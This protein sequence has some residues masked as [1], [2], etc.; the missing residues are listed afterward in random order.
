MLVNA[1]DVLSSTQHLAHQLLALCLWN[2]C[3]MTSLPPRFLDVVIRGPMG[4]GLTREL[5][6][7]HGL[8]ELTH[9]RLNNKHV[10]CKVDGA[11]SMVDGRA[12]SMVD[13]R[14]PPIISFGVT[15]IQGQIYCWRIGCGEHIC[16]ALAGDEHS[17]HPR[18]HGWVRVE[19][20][21]PRMPG[22]LIAK[23]ITAQVVPLGNAIGGDVCA[24]AW[25]NRK[26]TDCP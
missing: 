8:Y 23:P 3:A 14:E 15:M 26:F 22:N 7:L 9:E 19:F 13:G 24:R 2:G 10:W 1:A 25:D 11:R 20:G 17:S 18:Q 12:R 21:T 6:A 4:F 16:L 5:A